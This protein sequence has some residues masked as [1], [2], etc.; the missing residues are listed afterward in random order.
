M[1]GGFGYVSQ[2]W[3][4]VSATNRKASSRFSN[5]SY[6]NQILI[7]EV[8]GDVAYTVAIKRSTVSVDG[9]QPAET[10]RSVDCCFRRPA[11]ADPSGVPGGARHRSAG[12]SASP[13][14]DC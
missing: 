7:S 9:A 3:E 14:V 5:G 13:G 10:A 4:A 8:H 6:R 1:F 11:P 2:G 12:A